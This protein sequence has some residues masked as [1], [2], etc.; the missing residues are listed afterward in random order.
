MTTELNAASPPSA[1]PTPTSGA[2]TLA[3]TNAPVLMPSSIALAGAVI[4]ALQSAIFTY[5]GW[6]GPIYFSK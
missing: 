1:N 2:P 3:V 4:L 5:D 6:T